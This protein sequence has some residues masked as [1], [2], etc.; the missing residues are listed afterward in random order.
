MGEAGA[1]DDGEGGLELAPAEAPVVA[2]NKPAAHTVQLWAPAVTSEY[3]PGRHVVQ[4]TA[5]TSVLYAPEV[6]GTHPDAPVS[7]A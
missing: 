2:A 7:E 4:L 6:H 1:E 3:A 5:A